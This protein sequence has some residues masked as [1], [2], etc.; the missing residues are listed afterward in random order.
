MAASALRADSTLYPTLLFS[1]LTDIYNWLNVRISFPQSISFLVQIMHS[2]GFYHEHARSDRDLYIKIVEKNVRPGIFL[3]FVIFLW[4]RCFFVF[5]FIFH[6]QQEGYPSNSA[7]LHIFSPPFTTRRQICKLPDY[8]RRRDF[9]ELWL[10][11]QLDY[12]LW[13]LL[14]QVTK[15][16]ALYRI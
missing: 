4:H 12:A 11:L 9:A 13:T 16:I 2:L 7:K 14:F 5:D 3:C 1:Q 8:E 6:F 10:R 15:Y